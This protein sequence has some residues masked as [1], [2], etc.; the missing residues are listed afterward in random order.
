MDILAIAWKREQKVQNNDSNKNNW[1]YRVLCAS[2]TIDLRHAKRETYQYTNG[3]HIEPGCWIESCNITHGKQTKP[4][5]QGQ[6][7]MLFN[8][9]ITD[10]VKTSHLF[11]VIIIELK[12]QK[13]IYSII[14]PE[15]KKIMS[16]K[17]TW[18]NHIQKEVEKF[19]PP[20][21]SLNVPTLL[22]KREKKPEPLLRMEIFWY[23]WTMYEYE[24]VLVA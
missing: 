1:Y 22:Q 19:W 16:S 8:P 15:S 11:H 6:G 3:S 2:R 23:C 21:L 4:S 12:R 14:L 17:V 7:V 20:P 5:G 18:L 9:I 24:W 13:H 10:F